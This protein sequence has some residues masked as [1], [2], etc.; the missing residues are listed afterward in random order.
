MK[1]YTIGY[2]GRGPDEFL[3]LLKDN[4][5]RAVAD[6]RLRPDRSSMGTYVKAKD[7]DKGIEGCLSRAGI[8]YFSFVELG[9][10]FLDVDDWQV[11]YRHLMEKAGDL[12]TERLLR[13]PQPFC[14]MCS[15][16]SADRCHRT[17][18]AA[19]LAEKGHDVKHIE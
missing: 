12:L 11:R 4:G 13:V 10:L 5:I 7:P 19:Y 18:I 16:K 17:I 2:G 8:Q 3:R 1:L 9:N 15:E 14:L 6:V